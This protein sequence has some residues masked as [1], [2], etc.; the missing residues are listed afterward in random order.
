LIST[1]KIT[2]DTKRESCDKDLHVHKDGMPP[3]AITL[4]LLVSFVVK[5]ERS[6]NDTEL[7]LRLGVPS[8]FLAVGPCN[9]GLLLPFAA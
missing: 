1:T 4:C 5:K 9:L 7:G 3:I 8:L 2:K 6:Q